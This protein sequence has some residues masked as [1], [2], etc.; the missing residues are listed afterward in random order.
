MGSRD[1]AGSTPVFW[2]LLEGTCTTSR[3]AL[4]LH[5]PPSVLAGDGKKLGMDRARTVVPD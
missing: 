3:L 4:S 2:P 1:A 5:I